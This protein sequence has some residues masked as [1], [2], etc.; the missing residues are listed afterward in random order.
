MQQ[1]EQHKY[2]KIIWLLIGIVL[3]VL[4]LINLNTLLDVPRYIDK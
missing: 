2:R 3:C 4:L 1:T